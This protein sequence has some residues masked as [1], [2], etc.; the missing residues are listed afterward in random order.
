MTDFQGKTALVTGGARGIGKFIVLELARQG[1]QV[2]IS[3]IDLDGAQST[4]KEV[5]AMGIRALAVRNDVSD[6]VDVEKMIQTATDTFGRID[7]LVNNAGITRDSLLMRMSEAD[8]DLVLNINLKGA[9]LC[10]KAVIRGMMKQRSGKI[11][12]MASVVGVGGN[13][14]QANYAASKAGL[15]GL[16]KSVAKEV[17]S[18]N[19]QVNAIAPGYIETEMTANLP[20]EAKNWF[21]NNSPIKRPGTPEDV[22][23]AVL[24][25]ASSGSDYI[26]GQVIHVDGGMMM[27]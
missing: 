24:F 21:L 19:I 26:T 20:E 9:F 8:W 3:D 13:A 27:G 14:G 11:I 16:T 6:A 23:R 25:L 2:V 17:A 10:T 1:C 12:N 22:A 5:E 15:I 7:I 18:R 4:A